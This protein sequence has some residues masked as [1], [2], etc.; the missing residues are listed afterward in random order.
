MESDAELQARDEREFANSPDMQLPELRKQLHALGV[1]DQGITETTEENGVPIFMLNLD[2]SKFDKLDKAALARLQLD[3]RYRFE[4]KN[5]DQVRKFAHF[6]VAED[7]K[8]KKARSLREL[9][10]NGEVGKFPRFRAG[11]PMIAY[12]RALEHYCGYQPGEALNV[13]DGRW[14]EYRHR[15]VDK[16]VEDQ[17]GQAHGMAS[18][19]C[20]VRIVYATELQPHF[21]GNRGRTGETKI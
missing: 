20:V 17:D 12:A 5:P 15:M 4:L 16:A 2:A 11:I 21:I 18:F 7:T 14:L 13:V 6:S 10:E 1:T 3:S 9:A 19:K 8:R